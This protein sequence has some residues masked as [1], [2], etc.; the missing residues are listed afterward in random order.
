[1]TPGKKELGLFPLSKL[2]G[3]IMTL[4]HTDTQS[5]LAHTLIHFKGKSHSTLKKK[6]K[7]KTGTRVRPIILDS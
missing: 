1:M 7:A 5:Q 3:S 2:T 4:K 6:I